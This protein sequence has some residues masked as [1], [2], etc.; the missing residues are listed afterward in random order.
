MSEN[1][2]GFFT[3]FKKFIMRGNVID[4]AVGVIIASAFG[5]ITTSL[6]NDV[7]M[8]LLGAI[9]GKIDL[10]KLNFEIIPAVKDAS[11]AVVT[12]AVTIGFGTFLATIIDFILV[13]FII[14]LM[15]KIF[16][17]TREITEKKLLRKREEEP[18]AEPAG[19]KGEDLPVSV[20]DKLLADILTELKKQNS[21]TQ[22]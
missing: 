10:A 19:E 7:F 9:I 20:T 1:K 17:K 18:V 15:I 14:F 3:E 21:E 5:K 13:A 12:E 6:V 8:P 11:G 4:M 16:T 2:K 22:K